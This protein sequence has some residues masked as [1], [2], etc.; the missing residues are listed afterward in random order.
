[1]ATIL[2]L[3]R[4]LWFLIFDAKWELPDDLIDIPNAYNIVDPI[5]N[6]WF[7]FVVL[8]LLF[9][10]G[11]RKQNGLWSSQQG[12]NMGAGPK[13]AIVQQPSYMYGQPPQPTT[14]GAGAPVA[15]AHPQQQQQQ[16][17][18]VYYAAPIQHQQHPHPVSDAPVR[19]NK[20]EHPITG[21]PE[22]KP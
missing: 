8:V 13:P 20:E 22:M 21:Q 12:W 7:F 16:Q 3:I 5:F 14:Y 19:G 9:V 4:W 11:M 1:V 2:W 17:Q 6:V 18:P 15:Y 10:I